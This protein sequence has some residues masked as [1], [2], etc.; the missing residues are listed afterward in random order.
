MHNVSAIINSKPYQ[1]VISRWVAY[2]SNF[3]DPSVVLHRDTVS[4]LFG[5]LDYYGAAGSY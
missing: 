5:G 1:H 2:G 4:W 3:G